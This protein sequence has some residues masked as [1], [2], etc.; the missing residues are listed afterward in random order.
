MRTGDQGGQRRSSPHRLTAAS[1][2]AAVRTCGCARFQGRQRQWH[3]AEFGSSLAYMK[4]GLARTGRPSKHT[5]SSPIV[6]RF[7]VACEKRRVVAARRCAHVSPSSRT[8]PAPLQRS[9]PPYARRGARQERAGSA[10][11]HSHPVICPAGLISHP[12]AISRSATR[13][14]QTQRRRNARTAAADRLSGA[15]HAASVRYQHDECQ[16][17][18]AT[19][20]P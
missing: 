14:K 19:V 1:H 6:M 7:L 12:Y 16:G 5:P 2:A 4:S 3:H 9:H 15:E 17:I 8:P 20:L 13:D 10:C 18:P 11:A